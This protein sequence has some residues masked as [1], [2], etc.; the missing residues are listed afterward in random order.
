MEYLGIKELAKRYA[1]DRDEFMRLRPKTKKTV[2]FFIE[3]LHKRHL[4][5]S[6]IMDSE[7]VFLFFASLCGC[8][9]FLAVA[10]SQKNFKRS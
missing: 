4:K 3:W 7:R 5:K 2:I 10:N 1:E 6:D 8:L 9:K